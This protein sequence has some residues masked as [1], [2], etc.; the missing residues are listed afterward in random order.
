MAGVLLV[1]ALAML[2]GCDSIGDPNVRPASFLPD[3]PVNTSGSVQEKTCDDGSTSTGG[4]CPLPHQPTR[5][6]QQDAAAPEIL[7]IHA[8]GG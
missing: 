6:E 4:V 2:G 3:G 8:H 5:K 7:A 1:S